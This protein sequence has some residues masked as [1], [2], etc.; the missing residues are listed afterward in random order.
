MPDNIDPKL[1]GPPC[2]K[3]LHYITFSYPDSPNTTDKQNMLNFFNSFSKIIPCEKCR[4]NFGDHLIKYPL[5]TDILSSKINLIS[6]LVAIHNE[7][8]TL[9]GKKN[10]SVIDAI[11]MYGYNKKKQTWTLTTFNLILTILL[12]FLLI[13]YVRNK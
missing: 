12:I 3:T 2:W 6:W 13:F 9:V 8:N 7:V 11:T 4:V 1:W 10:V 5:S